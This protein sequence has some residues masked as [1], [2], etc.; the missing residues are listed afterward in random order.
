[1]QLE[2]VCVRVSRWDTPESLYYPLPPPKLKSDASVVVCHIGTYF[3][4]FRFQ[5]DAHIRRSGFEEVFTVAATNRYNYY[6]L[7]GLMLK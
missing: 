5:R 6:E 3:Y 2:C 1:M 7:I 4:S